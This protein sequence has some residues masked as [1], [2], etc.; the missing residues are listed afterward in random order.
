MIDTDTDTKI[1]R[2]RAFWARQNHDRPLIGFTGSYYPRQTLES[3]TVKEGAIRPE[4]VDVEAFLE[5]CEQEYLRWRH[6]MGD[7]IWSPT[8]LW[9]VPWGQ[10][11]LGRN[12]FVGE[13][14]IWNDHAKV[15]WDEIDR[16]C[17][18]RDNA[19]LERLLVTAERLAERA[20]GR[21][22]LSTLITPGVLV[23]LA[24]LRG[25][26]DL[27]F[28]I[29]DEPKRVEWA[30]MRITEALL[31]VL[32][33]YF[34]RLPA[35]RGGYGSHTRGV[36]APGR[37]IE[38]DEDS[39]YLLTPDM[40][41]RFVVPSHLRIVDGVEYAY[42]HLHST[43]LHTLDNLLDNDR[44]R[45]YELCPDEG[46][47][48]QETIGVLRNILQRGRCVITHAFFSADEVDQMIDALPPEGLYIGVRA[49]SVEQA[50][51]RKEAI[52]ERRGPGTFVVPP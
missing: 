50:M 47:D 6:H 49:T 21:Y 40:Q 30:M 33:R 26:T 27:V 28:D 44:I 48:L 1:D 52:M 29:T 42:C 32:D 13:G 3:L 25:M 38:F 10:A 41:R 16:L 51:A 23:V 7:A 35:W 4:D 14:A 36:W 22:P 9:G 24:E 15:D 45:Y 34:A 12:L 20:D 2:F 43:Q 18:L 5:H 31:E 17:E 46:Y 8:P 39:N 11:I 19:W 37:L